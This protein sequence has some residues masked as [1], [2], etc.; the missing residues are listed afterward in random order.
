MNHEDTR[1]FR[2]LK[3]PLILGMLALLGAGTVFYPEVY[4]RV[5]AV[6][7]GPRGHAAAS[8]TVVRTLTQEEL[9]WLREHPVIRVVQDPGWP[10]VEFADEGGEPSGISNDYLSLV[11]QRLGVKFE[12]VRNLTWQQAYSRL[13]RWDLDMTTCVAATP[14]RRE[15]WAFTKPYMKIPIVILAHTDVTYVASMGELEGK[16]VAVVDGYVAKEWIRRDFP[17]IR[18]VS[19]NS[20][21]EGL[22]LLQEK[23]V[24]AFVD[25]ML[26]IG[27]YLAQ[28]KLVNLKIAGTTPYVNAQCMAVR[29]D[30]GLLAGVLQKA[31]DSISETER[32]QIYQK[33]VPI[34]YEHG[35]DYKRLS[36]VAAIFA[37][38]LAG[39][40]AWNRKL[41]REIRHREEAE[42]AL[43]ESE[44]RHSTILK[45]AMDGFWTADTEGRIL[46][47]ND[48]YCKMIGYSREELLGM[49]VADVE[50]M[51]TEET[52]REHIR[53]II[54]EG[55]HRFETCHR[56]KDGTT[57]QMEVSVH[58]LPAYGGRLFTFLRD[59]TERKKAEDA[60]KESEER[61]RS[62]VENLNDVIFSMDDKGIIT[63]VSPVFERKCKYTCREVVGRRFTDLVHPDDVAKAAQRYVR[64]LQGDLEP[65]EYRLVDKEGSIIHVASYSRP[66]FRDGNL[67]GLT[68]LLTDITE[69]RQAEQAVR[70]SENDLRSIFNAISESVTLIKSNGEILAAN[71]SFAAR[72]G[73]R[74]AEVL[75]TC[76][77]D[78]FPSD[79]AED[80]KEMV[81]K[82]V[83]TARPVR[84]EDERQERFYFH[85]LYPVRSETGSVQRIAVYS[86]DVTARKQ[87][88][89]ALIE[90][91]QRFRTVIESAPVAIAFSRDL[92]TIYANPKY[93][94]MFGY[95]KP[96]DLLGSL[97]TERVST[98]FVSEFTH[99]AAPGA[100]GLLTGSNYHTEGVHRDGTRFPVQAS[101]STV[102][103]ADGPA[104]VGF[105]V[106]VTELKRAAEDR[107]RLQSQL[108][109]AQKMEAVGT[110]AGGIAHD[111]NNLLQVTLGYSE[112]LLEGKTQTD[113]DYPDLKKINQA[114]ASGAELV[115]N[116]MTFS[117]KVEPNFRPLD[118][119]H[120]ASQVAKILGRT[121][122][123]MIDIRLEL[124]HDLER[125][126]ADPAQIQQVIM[127]LAVNAKD[128]IGEEGTLTIRTEN[129]TLG[130]DYCRLRLNTEP[131]NY[132]LL[133][134]SDTGHGMGAET[135]QH[136]FEPFYTTKE[137]G[138]GTGLGLA[139][140]YG[141][142]KQHG[143]HIECRSVEGEGTTFKLYFP[144]IPSFEA[145]A[146]ETGDAK[147]A[148]GTE[149]VLLVD[150]E[151][152]VRE[153]GA[154]FLSQQGYTVLQATNGK[155][156]LDLFRKER[157]RI[158]LVILD[159]I[160][161]EMGGRECLKELLAVDP[162]AN[163]LV[164]SGNSAD[165]SV[166]DMIHIGAK[167]LVNKPFRR[168][169][170]LSDVRRVLD[171]G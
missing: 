76:I 71:E 31:L 2:W 10:P 52:I 84:A 108:L 137:L 9:S 145:P 112:L 92:K 15:F 143:G 65:S 130:E 91:E 167:G 158:S 33:W 95:E 160:M 118:L 114:A 135:L 23:Q 41:S 164:A 18:L 148:L 98:P 90:S 133:S 79:V 144:A 116:L 127:N 11:E 72:F 30:W 155:E 19:V 4:C 102:N 166:K 32:A 88:E 34:R 89:K 1:F 27:Y 20:V 120:S 99:Q 51:E 74:S 80:R 125:T 48:A 146:S 128:A 40:L 147:P 134:V 82:V 42:A 170:F 103:L 171:T 122:P 96:E 78:Y 35:F 3:S 141:V 47:V 104:T 44:Q 8:E 83:R 7:G 6:D 86:A 121:L 63:Y 97:I 162:Q 113:P 105:F 107:T 123:K 157:A 59:I 25:N 159:L 29:K 94:E 126:H 110:L 64:V 161:P 26:V 54:D 136:I 111:F 56:R 62:L 117:R 12:R 5:E 36:L 68:G 124:A 152:F 100:Q 163:I 151:E 61:Y 140:V 50:L 132:V 70:D 93:V 66:L 101:V 119:N 73:R 43:K 129:A 149:T 37:V 109:Q 75:G 14:E 153:L 17:Q 154:R 57:V 22:D 13:K 38:V 58:V 142:V 150:D 85:A 131:G 45:T 139:M 156:A 67:I 138:R 165:A 21:K 49:T 69:T 87:A 16:K 55:M 46:E 39:V 53:R 81:K 28:L 106:D 168:T 77:Y 60:L 24:F 169:D 115:R